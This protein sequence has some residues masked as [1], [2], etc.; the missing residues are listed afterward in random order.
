[1]Q[2]WQGNLS[3]A[4]E[5]LTRTFQGG[6]QDAPAY[7]NRGL[8][9]QLRGYQGMARAD[10]SRAVEADPALA[11]AWY[12][13]SRLLRALGENAVA[14]ADLQRAIALDRQFRRAPR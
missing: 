9:H 12:H 14:D 10:F 1:M 5:T 11:T 7:L 3:A 2:A 8:V 13:R 6:R 4:A